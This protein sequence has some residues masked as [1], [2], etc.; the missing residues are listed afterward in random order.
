MTSEQTKLKEIAQEAEIQAEE[1]NEN[2]EET[3][4]RK[5]EKLYC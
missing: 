2:S 3:G 4:K 1:K 5:R